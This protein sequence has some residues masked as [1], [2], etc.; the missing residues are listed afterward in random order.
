VIQSAVIKENKGRK[1]KANSV[2]LIIQF[3]VRNCLVVRLQDTF[4]PI[5]C[6]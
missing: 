5:A 2:F 4:Y 1:R 3:L 6:K